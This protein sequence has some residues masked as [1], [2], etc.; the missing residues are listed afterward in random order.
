MEGITGWAVGSSEREMMRYAI[1]LNASLFN[2]QRM[3]LQYLYEAYRGPGSGVPDAWALERRLS[4]SR[5][6]KQATAA[7]GK[8]R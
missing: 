6:A 8:T 2:S 5:R 1:A 4:H 7:G 3:L